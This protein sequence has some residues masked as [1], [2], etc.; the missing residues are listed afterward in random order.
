MTRVSPVRRGKEAHRAEGGYYFARSALPSTTNLNNGNPLVHSSGGPKSK[1]RLL[2]SLG[3][4]EGWR[5]NLS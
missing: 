4:S 1:V 3:L 5:E 2:A